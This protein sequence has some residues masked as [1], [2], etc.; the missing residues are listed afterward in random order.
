MIYTNKAVLARDQHDFHYPTVLLLVQA[1]IAVLLLHV[2]NVTL[3]T[4]VELPRMKRETIVNWLPV[5]LFFSA[6]LYSGSQTM[7]YL[8]IPLFTVFKNMTNLLIAYGDY[9]FFG[10]KVT[11]GVAACFGLMLVG[12][13][14]SAATDLEY[15][16]AGYAWVALNCCLQAGYVLYMRK[17]KRD[18]KLNEWGMAL[19]NNTLTV[20]IMGLACLVSGELHQAVTAFPHWGSSSFLFLLIL[21]GAV[22]TCLSL[23]VFWVVSETSPTTYSMIGATNKVPV[24]LI[25]ALF[26][27]TAISFKGALSIGI[28]I[29]SG[30]GYAYVKYR[31]VLKAR[32]EIALAELPTSSGFPNPNSNKKKTHS[33]IGSGGGLGINGGG[34]GIIGGSG[35]AIGIGG[36]GVNSSADEG[37]QDRTR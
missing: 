15:S 28:G 34:G 6:M 21:S 16:A 4:I 11:R 22:G 37:Q 23:A 18:T 19:Y 27:S 24:A 2:L 29:T 10:N 12:S 7:R 31:Q 30:I 20:A 26:F 14:L 33:G 35:T 36:V 5:T 9:H 3:P 17:A 25:S 13:V 8:S 1:A 32:N